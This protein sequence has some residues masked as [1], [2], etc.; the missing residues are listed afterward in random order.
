LANQKN[1]IASPAA[2]AVSFADR[3]S[4]WFPFFDKA[5]SNDKDDTSINHRALD[6]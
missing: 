3:C 1:E 4:G 5:D 2:S 6:G